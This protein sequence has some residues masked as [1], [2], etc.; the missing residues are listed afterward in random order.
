DF[1]TGDLN[2]YADR[3]YV[4]SWANVSGLVASGTPGLTITQSTNN[5]KLMVFKQG[6][7]DI[8]YLN[9]T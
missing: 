4:P 8:G 9:L 6:G 3:L 1:S 7:S 5:P 2:I